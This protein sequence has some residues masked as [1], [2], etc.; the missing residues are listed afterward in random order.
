MSDEFGL[1]QQENLEPTDEKKRRRRIVLWVS[2]IL[3][4]IVVIALI[5]LWAVRGAGGTDPEPTPTATASEATT[6]SA[7]PTP[8]P[9]PTAPPEDA[10]AITLP[11]ECSEAFSP[12]FFE[13][14]SSSGLPLNDPTVA[15]SPITKSESVERLREAL[16]H[17]RCTWGAAS[18]SGIL[19]AVN[20]VDEAQRNAAISALT[21]D[22]YTCGDQLGGTLCTIEFL[23]DT[24]QFA[25]AGES[26]YLRS[27]GWVSGYWTQI[28]FTGYTED[29]VA[30]LWS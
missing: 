3:V 28:D 1:P 27:N 11:T 25:A 7:T 22:G 16:P 13:S 5:V 19:S 18:D 2:L 17:L 23:D 26:H 4:A 8:T 29:I 20:I 10:D 9:T 15:D 30:T 6:P 14:L 12:A 24:G 21:A